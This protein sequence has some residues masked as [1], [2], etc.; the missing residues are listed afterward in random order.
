MIKNIVYAVIFAAV[1]MTNITDAT[2]GEQKEVPGWHTSGSKIINPEGETVILKSVSW[3]GFETQNLVPHG[4]WSR[5]M[6]EML[7]QMKD[8][9]FNSIRIPF[10]NDILKPGN[11]PNSINFH[12]NP[13][14]EG[15]T[16]LEVFD[17][18]IEEASKRGLYLVLDRHRPTSAQQSELWYT[19]EVSEEKWIQD[20]VFLADRYKSNPYVIAVDLHNEPHGSAQWGNGDSNTDWKA[21]AERAGNAVLKANPSLLII[22]EGIQF[23]KDWDSYWWGGALDKVRELPVTL[24]IANKVIYSPHDYGYGVWPQPWF[25]AADFPNNMDK[26]WDDKWGYIVKENIAPIWVGEFGGREVGYE[27]KEGIWQNKLV[28]YIHDNGM[29]FSYWS[30]NPNSGDTGGVLFDDWR[31]VHQEKVEMLQPILD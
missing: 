7:D 15:K 12:E 13:D 8:I 10:S 9:G 4:L 23:G 29:S 20:W 25:D 11:M 18:F 28:Q 17:I 6:G 3:F 14:L 22:V 5:N 27:T 26:V 1:A 21:A 2:E 30:W 16:A 24:D 19:G 31:T